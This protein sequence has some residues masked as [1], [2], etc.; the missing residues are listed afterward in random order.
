LTKI[1]FYNKQIKNTK[2]YAMKEFCKN[3]KEKKG[4]NK[5]ILAALMMSAFASSSMALPLEAKEATEQKQD[6]KALKDNGIKSNLTMKSIINLNF[7]KGLSQE[8]T[9]FAI[10]ENKQ[11][12]L[13][14]QGV[15]RTFTPPPVQPN[16]PLIAKISTKLID[17]KVRVVV[18]TKQ[19]VKFKFVKLENKGVLLLEE[20]PFFYNEANGEKLNGLNHASASN[21]QNNATENVFSEVTKINVKKDGL[22]NTKLSVELSNKISAPVI[23]KEGNKLIID[24]KNVSIPNELQR[25]VNTD[26]L[27]SISQVLDVSMQQSNG[28]I[29][30]EQKEGWDYSF[31][32]LEK[33][34]VIDVKPATQQQLDEE[35][36]Y[37]GK[38]LSIS[39]QDMEVRAILQ[40]IADFTGLNIMS[41]DKVLGTMTI[42]L[43]DVPWDQA[44]D[45]VLESRGL[46]KVK[47]GN[48]VWVAT[49]E[50]VTANN[51]AKL[52][53]KNQNVELEQLKLEFFQ[54]NYYKAEDLKKILEG[55]TN[56]SATSTNGALSMLSPRGTI[57][58]DPR[59]N[60]LFIQDTEDKLRDVRKLIKKLDISNRQVLVE[61]KIV[62][63]DS[64][65]G[66]DIG[67]RFGVRYRKQNGNTAVGVGGNIVESGNQAAGPITVTPLTAL[68]SGGINS[69][70]PGVIGL[71][72]LNAASGNALGVELS[73]LEQN[74]RGKVLSSPRL[75]TADNKKATIEQG[76]EIPYVTPGTNGSA[77]TVAFKKAV[78][79][80]DVTPQ[81]APNGKV[82]LDLNI[83]KDSI[84]Q[85]ISVQGG[86]QIP[87][88]DT[89]NINTLVTVNNGQTVV[90]GGVYEI[91]SHD[92]LS[93][94]PFFG[95]IPML[96]NL[97]KHTA[98]SENKGELMI[99]ITPYIIDD[100]DLDDT[101]KDEKPQEINL[102][103][104]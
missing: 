95:D 72:L 12:V 24:L 7:N 29:I 41:S 6:N 69:V 37:V 15:D 16:D 30:L 82:V 91:E 60:V 11:I 79:Q 102:S 33:Q 68:G 44:L 78:L 8:P 26:S 5:S 58:V 21:I 17:N 59:N 98:K 84:G 104:K 92:D 94:I 47:D 93:K 76:S 89:K 62:I 73:A 63:A 43:K 38:K 74:N 52:E 71:T 46:Q 42:R 18:E 90:L 28:R 34:F 70:S 81:I 9:V 56:G 61:A 67:T 10:P 22:K 39:F 101:A 87:S 96:G 50:E 36:K 27:N 53:L 25:R 45:L 3:I 4:T 40:V 51:K 86:G 20:S 97:F 66:R 55:K 31:Y 2:G 14:L 103:K 65:F 57:G 77:P 83:R 100:S 1:Y 99:F 75:L 35:K 49:T 88:I 32:Q 85:N 23:K 19:P 13:D 64:D 80:L 48:V 54:I